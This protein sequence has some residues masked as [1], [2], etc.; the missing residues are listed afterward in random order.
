MTKKPIF[1]LYMYETKKRQTLLLGGPT[2]NVRIVRG[3]PVVLFELDGAAAFHE[4]GALVMPTTPN[5]AALD[6]L[7]VVAVALHHHA[8]N[9]DAVV[10]VAGQR[11]R[12]AREP[13]AHKCRFRVRFAGPGGGSV[14][15]DGGRYTARAGPLHIGAVQW[16]EVPDR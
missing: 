4:G 10:L 9:V 12:P 1:D 14:A 3:R 13:F 5:G 2:T 16:F 11:T 8:D 6:G 7:S 15:R